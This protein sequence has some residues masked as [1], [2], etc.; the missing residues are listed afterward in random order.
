MSDEAMRIAHDLI[1]F[2]RTMCIYYP[3]AAFGILSSAMFQGVGK[4][5]YSL[6][7]TTVRTIVLV[8]PLTYLFAISFGLRLPGIWWGIVVGNTIGA[9]LAFIWARYTIKRLSTYVSVMQ[10]SQ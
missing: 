4:G 6:A 5:I 7:V 3:A 8:V 9:T 1:V 2:V 10:E